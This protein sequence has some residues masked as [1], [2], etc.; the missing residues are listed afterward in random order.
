MYCNVFGYWRRHLDCYFVLLTTSLVVTTI[1]FTV[2]HELVH[3][4]PQLP[5]WLL[6][7]AHC[8][9]WLIL[10]ASTALLGWFFLSVE[11]SPLI[12]ELRGLVWEHLV[13]GFSFVFNSALASIVSESNNLVSVC[14][15]GDAFSL[16][17]N[18]LI[19][20]LAISCSRKTL[21]EPFPGNGRLCCFPTSIFLPLGIVYRALLRNGLSQAVV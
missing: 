13:Q 10:S 3:V 21:A 14:C 1:T 20:F 2:R 9:D 7:L 12:V 11:I 8:F 18:M 16:L 17:C 5:H 19:L 4:C 6:A 15:S